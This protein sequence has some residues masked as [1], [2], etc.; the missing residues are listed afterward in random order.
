MNHPCIFQGS[1]TCCLMK[2]KC[3]CFEGILDLLLAIRFDRFLMGLNKVLRW[4]L[5]LDKRRNG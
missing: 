3:T 1:F 4:A 5:R 2:L